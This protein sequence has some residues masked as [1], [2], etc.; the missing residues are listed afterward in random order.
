AHGVLIALGARGRLADAVT[1][2]IFD[3]AFPLIYGLTGLRPSPT[4]VVVVGSGRR[5]TRGACF[6][7]LIRLW[8]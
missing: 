7:S 3:V 4:S 6:P 2:A 8:R 1:L 5:V